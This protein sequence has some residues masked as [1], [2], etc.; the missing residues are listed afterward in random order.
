MLLLLCNNDSSF[1]SCVSELLS[2]KPERCSS[3][4]LPLFICKHALS[5][6]VT[7]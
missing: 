6:F 7:C 5:M 2:F 3:A 1:E 4:M